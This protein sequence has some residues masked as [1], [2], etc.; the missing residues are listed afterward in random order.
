MIVALRLTT[1]EVGFMHT[2]TKNEKIFKDDKMGNR[3]LSPII[4][5]WIFGYR[6]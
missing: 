1:K 5:P 6:S 4:F 2:F 3:I